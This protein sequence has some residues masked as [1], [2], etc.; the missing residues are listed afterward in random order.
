[1]VSAGC[2]AAEEE[3]VELV[4][5]APDG[6]TLD[7]WT[8]RR[9]RG[10]PLAW[11]TGAVVFCG[12]R[13]GVAAGV[14]VPRVQT[15]ELARRAA[16]LL[17]AHGGRAADLCT[18]AGA[19]AAHVAEATGVPVV[20]TDIDALALAC[21]RRNGVRAVMGDLG[22]PLRHGAFSVVTAVAPY[23]P[24]GAL[25]FLPADVRRYEPNTAL[26][27]GADGLDVVRRVVS[28]AACLLRSGGW[29]LLEVGGD[30]DE[31]LAPDLAACGFAPPD[32][33][34][35]EDEDLRGLVARRG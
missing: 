25:A 27:G 24:T 34:R 18:G 1:L 17:V 5:S 23:V 31:E 3:A 33:W 9:E 10:E 32:V 26:D 22:A 29:L 7:A 19:V 2:V 11:I 15:E 14:Y 30:Q 21:A 4:A 6:A 8:A 13:V 28:D 35:D 20:G 12:R 16:D